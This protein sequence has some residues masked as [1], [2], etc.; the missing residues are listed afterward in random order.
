MDDDFSA[1][2][3]VEIFVSYQ[4][5]IDKSRGSNSP[6]WLKEA[7]DEDARCQASVRDSAA[8]LDSL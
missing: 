3:L 2:W 5:S 8:R 1:R 7:L 6:M 4:E